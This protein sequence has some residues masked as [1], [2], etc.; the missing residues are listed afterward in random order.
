MKQRYHETFMHISHI[1]RVNGLER[2]TKRHS[3]TTNQ[4]SVQSIVQL[5]T[6]FYQQPF[7]R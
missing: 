1:L 2:G 7:G 4:L 5:C 3:S 6:V